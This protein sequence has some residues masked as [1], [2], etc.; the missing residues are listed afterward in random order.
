MAC[1]AAAA[2]QQHSNNRTAAILALHPWDLAHGKYRQAVTDGGAAAV[3]QD[4]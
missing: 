3:K 2:Q 1:A 4:H